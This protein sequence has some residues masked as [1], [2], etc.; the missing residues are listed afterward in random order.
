MRFYVCTIPPPLPLCLGFIKAMGYVVSHYDV[1]RS[2]L[3]LLLSVYKKYL[4]NQTTCG[5]EFKSSCVPLQRGIIYRAKM[6]I[7]NSNSSS[8]YNMSDLVLI[9][10]LMTLTVSVV[11]L[12]TEQLNTAIIASYERKY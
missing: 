10:I 1:C 6:R 2:H 8:I 12:L 4:V 3:V 11:A 7:M 9:M 5:S